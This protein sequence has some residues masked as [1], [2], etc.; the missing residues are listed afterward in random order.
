MSTRTTKRCPRVVLLR[1]EDD[2][3]FR[4]AF[5]K[6]EEFFG[7]A[8]FGIFTD[9]DLHEVGASGSLA[10]TPFISSARSTFGRI[11]MSTCTA[12]S[13]RNRRRG[14]RRPRRF[15]KSRRRPTCVHK[16]NSTRTGT[17]SV[18][19]SL[20][21]GKALQRRWRSGKLVRAHRRA[22]EDLGSSLRR[23]SHHVRDPLD[24][25]CGGREFVAKAFPRES[26]PLEATR[27]QHQLDS[28]DADHQE[29]HRG[30]SP[31]GAIGLPLAP[32]PDRC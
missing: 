17:P 21:R 25:A 11:S 29:A 27:R 3:A 16:P 12:S 15:G 32:E 5:E 6:F 22:Q 10:T 9:Q 31:S 24:P 19:M 2:S 8:P 4:W 18:I 14:P 7:A 20:Q 30:H 23:H 28:R 1:H 13:C 26:S